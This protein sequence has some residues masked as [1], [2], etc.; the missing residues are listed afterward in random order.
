MSTSSPFRVFGPS[1]SIRKGVAMK[2]PRRDR[3]SITTLLC[4]AFLGLSASAVCM[5]ETS[6]GRPVRL[7]LQGAPASAPDL[8]IRPIVQRLSE[9]SGKQF[10]VDNRPG[11]AGLVAAQLVAAAPA[12]G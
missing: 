9:Q 8:I 2:Y 10:I 1:C 12:D 7:V 11:A 6:T 4:S 3:Q 5:A